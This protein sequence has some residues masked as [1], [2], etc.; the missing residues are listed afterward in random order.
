[1]DKIKEKNL[2][3]RQDILA[4]LNDLLLHA[5]S[6]NINSNYSYDKKL[7]LIEKL[8]KIM[9]VRELPVLDSNGDWCYKVQCT[10]FGLYLNMVMVEDKQKLLADNEITKGYGYNLIQLKSRYLT[11]EQF[12]DLN[13]TTKEAVRKQLRAG[14]LPYAQKFGS[15]WL[16]PEFSRPLRD[17]QLIGWFDLSD[18]IETFIT[19][20]GQEIPLLYK[21]GIDIKLKGRTKDKKKLFSVTVKRYDP[22]TWQTIDSHE[23][24]LELVDKNRLLFYLISD[25][26][27]SYHSSSIGIA[28]WLFD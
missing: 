25:P 27:A 22:T 26:N 8:Q 3:S 9:N 15:A 16:I 23:Y 1:M 11:I 14:Q 5:N 2:Y 4:F 6:L 18:N 17:D 10:M 12:A 28:N 7:K 20:D 21:S 24:M 19:L 13:N